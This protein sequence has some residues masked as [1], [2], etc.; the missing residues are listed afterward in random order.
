MT[1]L[2]GARRPSS[3]HIQIGGIDAYGR[4]RK[5]A[6]RRVALMPQVA[7]FPRNM[8]AFEVVHYLT[9]MRGG[10]F[11]DRAGLGSRRAG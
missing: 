8:S 7:S 4:H 10:W 11:A 2:C 1:T 3:G 6:L 9:W 5:S